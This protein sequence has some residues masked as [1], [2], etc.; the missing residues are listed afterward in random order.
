MRADGASDNRKFYCGTV[1][2]SHNAGMKLLMNTRI[3]TLTACLAFATAAFGGQELS[4]L[5][6]E[7]QRAYL[8]GELT[9]AKEKF[10]IVQK[11]DPQNRIAVS[12]LRR[13]A[14][15][16]A[17]KAAEQGPGN[18]TKVA[19]T[20][21]IMPKIDFREASLAEALEFLRQKGNQL[22]DGK[23]AINFVVQLDDAAKATK[24]TLS[25]S[26]VPFSEIL[27]YIGDLARV[28]FVYDRFA[29]FVKPKGAT[30]PATAAPAAQSGTG[31]KVEGL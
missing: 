24:I 11:L 14:A 9:A 27:R 13:I 12:S 10:E 6:T 30:A 18:A 31:I 19:L 23:T 2:A 16:E 4:D 5:L 21:L 26:N 22:D 7:A 15:D 25:L 20:K 1:A 3:I 8:R 28:D 17:K 29:I